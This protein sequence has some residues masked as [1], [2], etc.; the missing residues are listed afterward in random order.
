MSEYQAAMQK[1]ADLRSNIGNRQ[2]SSIR[3]SFFQEEKSL[4]RECSELNILL[5]AIDVAED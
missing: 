4:E 3:D 1:L 5:E 2:Q